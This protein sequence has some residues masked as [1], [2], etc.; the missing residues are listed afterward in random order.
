MGDVINLHD[1][2]AIAKCGYCG[3][4]L[5]EE[6][7]FYQAPDLQFENYCSENCI[8]LELIKEISN[9][10]SNV[11]L[12]TNAFQVQAHKKRQNLKTKN[13]ERL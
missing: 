11:R 8:K 6:E 10:E 5:Y 7:T 4:K 13:P 12:F 3:K 2:K 1:H 9:P